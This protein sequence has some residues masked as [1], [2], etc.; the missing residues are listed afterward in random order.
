MPPTQQQ[1][2]HTSPLALAHPHAHA[3]RAAS[4]T[5][6]G[7][8]YHHAGLT[9]QERV[10]VEG[11]YRSGALLVLA[12]TSTL[13]AGVNLPARRVILRSLKQGSTWLRR[14]EYLQMAGRAGRAGA[15]QQGYG[16]WLGLLLLPFAVAGG[17]GVMSLGLKPL[18]PPIPRIGHQQRI[19]PSPA[20]PCCLPCT[21]TQAKALWGRRS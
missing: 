8:A 14:S 19:T 9:H 13:A 3:A 20:L 15:A 18:T 2:C 6:A 17:G 5:A 16:A 12:A 7:V 1:G 21:R 4:H 10:A 11:G